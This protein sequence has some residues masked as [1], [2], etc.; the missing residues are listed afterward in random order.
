MRRAGPDS[1]AAVGSAVRQSAVESGLRSGFEARLHAQLSAAGVAFEYEAARLRYRVEH[2]YTPDFRIRT[3]SGRTLFIEAKGY[4]TAEDRT[5]LRTVADQNPL[6]D[7]RIVFQRASSPIR[8]GSKT[9]YGKWA[10]QAG[11]KWAE[12]S[13]PQDWLDE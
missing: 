5:K 4:F 11:F 3:R 12:G 10:T 13:I 1:R 2:T 9:T 7:I 8:K 6:A